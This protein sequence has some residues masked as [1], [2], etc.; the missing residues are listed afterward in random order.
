MTALVVALVAGVIVAAAASVATV[1]P[2]AAVP[3]K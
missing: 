1:A 3:S 2:G